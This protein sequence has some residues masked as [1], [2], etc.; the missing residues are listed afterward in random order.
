MAF[1]WVAYLILQMYFPLLIFHVW[2]MR[3]GAFGL[4][5]SSCFLSA[6]VAQ[7]PDHQT[8]HILQHHGL[9]EHTREINYHYII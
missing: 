8:K 2:R 6:T 4:H 5:K 7:S 9:H 3:V 1:L